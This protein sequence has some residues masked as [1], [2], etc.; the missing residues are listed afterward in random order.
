MKVLIWTDSFPNYS[1]TFIRNQITNLIDR[2]VEVFIY[3][4]KKEPN[5]L[6]AIHHLKAYDL[7]NKV[8][9]E[10]DVVPK[11]NVYRAV[12]ALF[13]I[14]KVVF[15]KNGK[16][17]L[18]TLNKNKFGRKATTLR[19]F[20]FVHF[21][22]KNKI[23]VLH[24][25]FGTN[26]RKLVFAKQIELP[27]KLI[28]TF[29]GYDIRMGET[30]NKSFYEGLFTHADHIISISNYNET[31]LLSFGL[32]KSKIVN[33]NNG[34]KVPKEITI[35]KQEEAVI[36]I[37]SVGRL[38]NEK[39]YHLALQAIAKIKKENPKLNIEYS[40]AGD[41]AL[42]EELETLATEL[43]IENNVIFHL[44]QESPVIFKLIEQADF[45]L[46]T[47]IKEAMPTVILEAFAREL[48]VAATNVGSI[49]DIVINT[50]TG[51]LV[52]PTEESVYKGLSAML[53]NKAQ[54]KQFGINGRVLVNEHYN[55]DKQI[56]KMI[57]L[58]KS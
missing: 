31:K 11:N 57:T 16:Y 14:L 50:E 19:Y 7:I 5:N 43:Q 1:E 32:D 17:Y 26:G 52:E 20:Y 3:T 56:E 18:R 36:K 55:E 58:Y 4:D 10:Q 21:L 8:V 40:I 13:I 29:H 42:K 46:L 39:A 22:I 25:H 30:S 23:N 35:R 9:D 53:E 24:A 15:T 33:I 27:V 54:W 37:L 2:G 49:K 51:I 28:C 12:K 38:V 47:S 6:E 41:G 34:V 48:P 45:L 44:Y